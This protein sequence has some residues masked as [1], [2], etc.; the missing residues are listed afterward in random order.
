MSPISGECNLPQFNKSILS[1]LI[2]VLVVST[3]SCGNKI[4]FFSAPTPTL[5]LTPT[6]TC[7]PTSTIAPPSPP[8]ETLVPPTNSA[9]TSLPT[10]PSSSEYTARFLEVLPKA[11]ASCLPDKT[12]ED[13]GVYI[14]DL[15]KNRELISINADVPFQ[16]ASAFKGPM[17]VYFLS[18]CKKFW[19][20][21]SPEWNA[22][23]S[24]REAA[25]NVD[26][27]VSAEY[28]A[29]ISQHL[30]NVN[31]WS[32]VDTF[33]ANH[34]FTENGEASVI[35]KR[36][37][38]LAQVYSMAT[39]SNNVAA[40]ELLRFVYDQCPP[41]PPPA[42]E[43]ACRK[44]N[45]I[46]AFNQWFNQ[47]SGVQYQDGEAQRGLFAWDVVI[48][49][50][51][52]GKSRETTMATY[53][54]KDNCAVQF[55]LLNCNPDLKITNVWTARDFFKFYNALYRLADS[56]IRNAALAMLT[57]D[58]EGGARGDLK[59]LARKMGAISASKNGYASFMN[60]SINTDA[61]IFQYQGRLFV[62][63]TL[64]YGA[65]ISLSALY[66]EYTPKGAPLTDQSLIQNFLTEYVASAP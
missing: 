37:F 5:T 64:T 13:I 51:A 25:R 36:F 24:D 2:V 45:A 60:N 7:T 52:N 23:F 43:E 9:I 55:T 30:S 46:S 14:Y 4:S 27:Y 32:G 59:N 1:L 53:G 21:E 63:V 56:R 20:T 49:P 42:I 48:E 34:K 12:K 35:D 15:N 6:P 44:P 65:P 16:F 26:W 19:D 22:Y 66:G 18:S 61:G 57:I 50:D 17:L 10:T 58:N 8:I 33:F 47:F 28:K 3:L 54:L 62:V 40:G 39:L 29:L 41:Q 31:N 38:V 11:D